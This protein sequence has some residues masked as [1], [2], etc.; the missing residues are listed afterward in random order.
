MVRKNRKAEGKG[1][2]GKRRRGIVGAAWGRIGSLLVRR[3][4]S[5]REGEERPAV[6]GEVMLKESLQRLPQRNAKGT[7]QKRALVSVIRGKTRRGT[8]K[9]FHT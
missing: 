1:G 5:G 3:R 6:K 8:I 9:E 2:R 7:N 4:R